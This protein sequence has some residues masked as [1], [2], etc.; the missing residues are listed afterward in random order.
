M[1]SQAIFL[2]ISSCFSPFARQ[3]SFLDAWRSIFICSFLFL[4]VFGAAFHCWIDVRSDLCVS[5][6]Y[7]SPLNDILNE[8]YVWRPKCMHN[9][10]KKRIFHSKDSHEI[11]AIGILFFYRIDLFFFRSNSPF[12][13]ALEICSDWRLKTIETWYQAIWIML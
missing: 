7:T 2:G 9:Q 1:R 10:G 11:Y 5:F 6:F 4:F 12:F 13:F 8:H 3:L